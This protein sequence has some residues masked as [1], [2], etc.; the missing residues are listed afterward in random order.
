LVI[1]GNSFGSLIALGNNG[2][3]DKFVIE[4]DS[5]ENVLIN[6]KSNTP[7][8]FYTNNS[9]RFDIT[10]TGIACFAC[11][12]CIP[13]TAV[14][15]GGGN[16]LILRKGTGTPAIA[17]AGTSDEATFLVEG[18]SGGGMKWYTSPAGC[19]LSNAAWNA[20]FNMDVNGISTF[21]CT[22]CTTNIQTGANSNLS[23]SSIRLRSSNDNKY[24]DI[25]SYNTCNI[26]NSNY[27]DSDVPL[28]LG[29]FFGHQVNQLF[30]ATNC[31]VGIG[32]NTPN[33]TLD[34][35]GTIQVRGNSLGYATTQCV[36]QLDFYAGAARLLSFG[37]NSST[38]GGFRFYSAG[39]NN[40]GGSDVATISGGGVACFRGAVCASQI[41]TPNQP[42]ATV[43]I[44]FSYGTAA[45]T[46]PWN[47][48]YNNVGGHYN[49]STGYFTAP[50][51]GMYLTSIMVMSDSVDVTM[52]IG[53]YINN[54]ISNALVPY[55]SC[56]GGPYNQVS[57]MTIISL[58]ANDTISYRINGG[59]IYGS[60]AGRHNSVVFRLLG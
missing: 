5:G 43:G 39:Q 14:I 1:G 33:E 16:T 20:K 36:T 40:A 4:S 46:I 44:T 45:T 15:S 19:T 47:Y 21:S 54:N 31:N 3:G 58:S 26:I 2:N 38:C 12:V 53:L 9:R 23:K 34:V 50:V 7:M 42:S 8:I 52:D 25:N 22:V 56:V 37:G 60:A 6:N 29:T 49:S 51:S 55:Q 11:Q 57:G 30:L 28:I 18:M 32:T 48:V 17:F 27:G 59:S 24:L 13:S 10:G 41:L 35:N